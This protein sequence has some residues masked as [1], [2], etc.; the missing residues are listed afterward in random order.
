MI[1]EVIATYHG[2]QDMV[3]A[4]AILQ[5]DDGTSLH[6]ALKSASISL[7]QSNEPILVKELEERDYNEEEGCYYVFFI[8]PPIQ[9]HLF[10]AFEVLLKDDRTTRVKNAVS[11]SDELPYDGISSNPMLP[12]KPVKDHTNTWDSDGQE[13]KPD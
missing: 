9:K 13:R 5:E 3:Q 8:H 11:I 7:L 12:G 2:T 10:V 6:R 4:T 1:A